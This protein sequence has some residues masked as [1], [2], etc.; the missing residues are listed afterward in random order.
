[1]YGVQVGPFDDRAVEELAARI[2]QVRLAARPQIITA[3]ASGPVT[4]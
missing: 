3:S 2:D 1:V 4:R